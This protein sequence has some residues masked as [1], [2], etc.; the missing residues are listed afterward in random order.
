MVPVALV[1]DV[2]PPL[3]PPPARVVVVAGALL[4]LTMLEDVEPTPVDDEEPVAEAVELV[5][6][7]ELED[8]AEVSEAAP[9]VLSVGVA[10]LDVVSG[11]EVAED[12]GL[13]VD[14]DGVADALETDELEIVGE[15]EGDGVDVVLSVLEM[16]LELVLE[17]SA[18]EL[19]EVGDAVVETAVEASLEDVVVVEMMIT[20][21]EE[22]DCC[23]EVT[24]DRVEVTSASGAVLLVVGELVSDSSQ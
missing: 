2:V 4:E 12:R 10:V 5:L 21:T 23:A 8:G 13:E 14:G 16:M 22:P 7:W 11:E 6:G 19:I 3:P 15:G 18:A 9:E 20:D 17:T 24:T 1:A